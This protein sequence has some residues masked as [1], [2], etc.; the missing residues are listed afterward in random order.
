MGQD[1]TVPANAAAFLYNIVAQ[2][3]IFDVLLPNLNHG[4]AVTG[5]GVNTFQQVTLT[6][7]S[8]SSKVEMRIN[9]VTQ[10]NDATNHQKHSD[11]YDQQLHPSEI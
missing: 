3:R 8:T 11:H 7:S 2:F 10:T 6:W 9:N 5:T 4:Y 1:M